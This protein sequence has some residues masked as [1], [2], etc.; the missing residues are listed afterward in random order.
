MALKY[1]KTEI[2]AQP[3]LRGGHSLHLAPSALP[4]QG[5]YCS[6]ASASLSVVPYSHF[7]FRQYFKA[8]VSK[9]PNLRGGHRLHLAPS[10]LPAQGS[11]DFISLAS[12]TDSNSFAT[13]ISS[14]IV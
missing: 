8:I 13:E 12:S 7:P 11:Y 6:V 4:A 10:V 5:S 2:S 3:I 1:F 14:S 9:Q